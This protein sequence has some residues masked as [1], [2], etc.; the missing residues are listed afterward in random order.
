MLANNLL[1]KYDSTNLNLKIKQREICVCSEQ[2][3]K[4]GLNL[5]MKI[6][7]FESGSEPSLSMRRTQPSQQSCLIGHEGS[8]TTRSATHYFEHF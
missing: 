1:F 6:D 3:H 7:L 5:I 8:Y 4:M 2:A